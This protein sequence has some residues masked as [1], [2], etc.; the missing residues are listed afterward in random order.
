M[1]LI[2]IRNGERRDFKLT[3]EPGKLKKLEEQFK[4]R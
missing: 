1:T 3:I 2:N 4:K